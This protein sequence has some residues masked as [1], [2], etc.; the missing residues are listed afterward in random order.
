MSKSEL[1]EN[2]EKLRESEGKIA[3]AT[4][5]GHRVFFIEPDPDVREAHRHARRLAGVLVA[6]A[7]A[8]T[9]LVP[10]SPID[11]VCPLPRFANW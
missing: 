3:L 4:L 11:P 6:P 7:D 9:P 5:D 8:P 2:L 10:W 1:F